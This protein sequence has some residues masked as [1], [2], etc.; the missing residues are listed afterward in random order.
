MLVHALVTSIGTSPEPTVLLVLNRL[1]EVLAD[2]VRS[3]SRVAVLAENDLA[4]L[5]LIPVIDSI[6]LLSLFLRRLHVSRVGVQISLG[7][8][9]LHASIVTELALAAL[10]AVALLVENAKNSLRINTKRHLLN[11]NRLEQLQSL[12]LS[13]LR[14]LLLSLTT[15]LLGFLLLRVSSLVGLRLSL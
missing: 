11:L 8:L 10:F 6:L 15:S 3:R 7:R 2:L 14:S 1:N 9:A 12:L 5:L 13:L 4:K